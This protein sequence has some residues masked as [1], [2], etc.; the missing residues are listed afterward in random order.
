MRPGC[1]DRLPGHP[2]QTPHEAGRE[3]DVRRTAPKADAGPPPVPVVMRTMAGTMPPRPAMAAVGMPT[4]RFSGKSDLVSCRSMRAATW[5]RH[6]K[7]ISARR[8]RPSGVRGAHRRFPVEPGNSA[9]TFS[10]R[11]SQ[12][13]PRVRLPS[14]TPAAPAAGS[15]DGRRIGSGL[16]TIARV[17][18][19]ET[20]IGT[21]V[22]DRGPAGN[23]TRGG[24]MPAGKSQHV[25]PAP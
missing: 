12:A 20:R 22:R 13:I 6:S 1:L 19:A 17:M 8:R 7:G 18:C 3:R 9:S 24:F 5:V 2:F 16:P 14:R 23:P 25:R 4:P 11:T 21:A 10:E 15:G